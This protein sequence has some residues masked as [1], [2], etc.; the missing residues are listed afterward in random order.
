MMVKND[1]KM[2]R[3]IRIVFFCFSLLLVGAIDKEVL[4]GEGY[5]FL[6]TENSFLV[7]DASNTAISSGDT[8]GDT[9][10]KIVNR[11]TGRIGKGIANLAVIFLAIGLFMGK[12]NWGQAVAIAIGI[13]G[14]F[15]ASQIVYWLS[16]TPMDCSTTISG[17]EAPPL[18]GDPVSCNK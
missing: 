7:A 8:I 18:C 17:P 3:Y 13:A 1:F 6:Q 4:A 15:G 14:I 9:L 5:Q 11:L 2:T 16:G 10:C 12:A